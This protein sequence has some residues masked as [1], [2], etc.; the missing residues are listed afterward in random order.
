VRVYDPAGVYTAVEVETALRAVG[1]GVRE[2]SFRYELL[3]SVNTLLG[4]LDVVSAAS[5]ANNM[6]ADIKRT[7]KFTIKDD[8]V[9]NY[10][11]NRIKPYVRLRMPDGGYV[12]WP[13][14]VFLL[15][16]PARQWKAGASLMREVEG[17]DQLLVL[18]DNKIEARY[19]AESGNT[20]TGYVTALLTEAG[21]TD[22]NI[23]ASALTLPTDREWAPDTTFLTII[24][25]LLSAINYDSLS[26][27][28]DGK[29][30]AQPYVSPADR[31][32]EFTYNTGETGVMSGDVNQ[33]LDL[34]A[35]PNKWVITVSSPDQAVLTSSYTNNGATSPTSTVSRGRTIVDFRKLEEAAD[36]TTLDNKV[37]R[38]AFN[39]SQVYEVV[40][41][42]SLI[43]PIHQN[44]DVVTV[45][46]TE[47]GIA[48][49]FSEHEW[50]M[51]LKAGMKMTHKFRRIVTLG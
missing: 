31:T 14:G 41:F 33:T 7:A 36:Q 22:T 20:Y 26:F 38:I 50:T 11:S 6:F 30:I 4:D 2:L 15:S 28:E 23:T 49:S 10:L 17:Y 19:T 25:N 21:I 43:M 37:A 32:S 48:A 27:D 13:Q 45:G 16:T 35:V 24:N 39:A 3:N 46:I 9:I 18:M 34:F 44:A 47:M 12:E 8:S 29:A 51:P 1:T 40:E 42:S 5:V